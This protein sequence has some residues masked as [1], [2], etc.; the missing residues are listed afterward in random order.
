MTA[1]CGALPLLLPLPLL[2]AMSERSVGVRIDGDGGKAEARASGSTTVSRMI[3]R[4]RGCS[5]SASFTAA[6]APPL[7]T[8]VQPSAPLKVNGPLCAH[9]LCGRSVAARMGTRM[10]DAGCCV[11]QARLNVFARAGR[12]ETNRSRMPLAN[13]VARAPR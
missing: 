1:A 2:A 10:A 13:A 7:A 3:D 4:S 8:L 6:G 11:R 12:V 5:I 9:S